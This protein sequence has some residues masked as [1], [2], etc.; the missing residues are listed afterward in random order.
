MPAMQALALLVR[1]GGTGKT[2]CAV[3][4]GVLGQLTGRRV[5]FFDL[6]PQRSLATWWHSRE[7][8]TP[9]LVE[10]EASRLPGC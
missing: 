10:T 7:A 2:T 5:L 8:D 6:D 1:K 4:L 9:A 3:H